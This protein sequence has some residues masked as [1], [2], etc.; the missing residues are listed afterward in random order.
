VPIKVA[1]S[2]DLAT[3]VSVPVWAVAAIGG[4]A[5]HAPTRSV[6]DMSVPIWAAATAP[7]RVRACPLRRLL[8]RYLPHQLQLIIGAA[9]G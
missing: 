4:T 2:V 1:I 5:P 7:L 3:G 8:S 9:V 6:T